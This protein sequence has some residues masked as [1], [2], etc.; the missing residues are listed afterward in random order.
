MD[1]AHDVNEAR[2]VTYR[3]RLRFRVQKKLNISAA[4]HTL[5]VADQEVVLAAE[6]PDTPIQASGWLV[7]NARGF[8]SEADAREFGHKLRSA[9]EVSSV[10]TRLGVDAGRD[11]AT[12]GIGKSVRE[13]I[14]HDTGVLVRNDVHGLDVFVDDP[15]VRFFKLTATGSVSA[16]PDAFLDGLN[17][18]H[19]VAAKASP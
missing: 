13:S 3:A 15:N 7:M 8:A 1:D 10:A 17:E 6:M 19:D 12:S 16:A 4:S 18:L 11:L 5:T 2:P 9:V 14:A